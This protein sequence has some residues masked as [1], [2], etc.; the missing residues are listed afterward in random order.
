MKVTVCV[1]GR[2]V[3]NNREQHDLVIPWALLFKSVLEGTIRKV[4][5]LL[6]GRV[7]LN[8]KLFWALKLINVKIGFLIF[9]EF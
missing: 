3:L 1:E 8:Y 4:H 2:F 7:F 9:G 5:G 6:I